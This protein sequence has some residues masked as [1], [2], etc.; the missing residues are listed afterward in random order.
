MIPRGSTLRVLCTAAVLAVAL[1]ATTG[2]PVPAT[3]TTTPSTL[4]L[5]VPGPLNGCTVLDP[6]ATPTTGAILD[7]LRPSAFLTSPTGNLFGEGG[8]LASAE[9]V[10]LKPETVVYTIAPRQH[11]SNGDV[12]DGVDLVAWWL[13]AKNLASV[14]SDGYR[15]IKSLSESNNGL[16]V[17]ATFST[18]YAEWNLLFRDVEDV[19]ASPG[20]SWSAFNHRPTLGPY[21]LV[22]AGPHQIV[23]V[24]NSGW[25]LNP[26]RFSRV[27][28]SDTGAFPSSP[29]AFFV[30]YSTEVNRTTVEA[31]SGHPSVLGH[32]GNY[33]DIEQLRFAP[34]R[35]LTRSL[36]IREGLSWSINRQALI[37]QVF[38]S[39]TF[40]PSVASSVLYSQGQGPYPGGSGNGPTAQSTT[41]T[42]S[43]KPAVGAVAD[44]ATCAL[45]A[46]TK[47][48]YRLL[49][50]GWT[51]ANGQLL[52]VHLAVGPS[53]MDRATAQI[54]VAQWRQRGIR[55]V[56][57]NVASDQAAAL[58]A[59]N[60]AVDVALFLRPTTTTAA[61]S[62]RSWSGP[63]YRDAY[64]SGVDSK[65]IDKFYKE[66]V[67][68]F[69][70]VSA[71][72]TWLNL[73]ALVMSDFLARP[74][75][76]EP[77]L[78]EWSNTILNTY[79]SISVPGLV[80]QVPVWLT[81]KGSPK[82]S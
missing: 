55:V 10:S 79:S 32:I 4:N 6:G 18:N 59:A 82:G 7:L 38:G 73:D 23:L 68:N 65:A 12:F 5:S 54:L 53:A 27:V 25:T 35:P 49:A 28:I 64:P 75:F 76:T 33:S 72:V 16:T 31:L 8:S 41:T 47:A 46:F 66:G 56:R 77:S 3:A 67:Q 21:K 62:A 60:D 52:T 40:S 24:K 34:D 50:G 13:K 20:C 26:S 45:S 74:L 42:I 29:S 51:T 57:M 37:N 63:A 30:G 2:A 80:D 48:G 9:L 11:W 39:V 81:S 36:L 61:Y 70:P 43:T 15:A 78:I 22:S 14:Q 71:S 58:A 44:C 1:I 19:G 69:N 17:T